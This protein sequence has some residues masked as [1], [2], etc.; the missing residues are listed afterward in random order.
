MYKKLFG[1]LRQLLFPP[2]CRCCGRKLLE[3]ESFL[4]GDCMVELPLT[5]QCDHPYNNFVTKKFEDL[6]IDK[7]CCMFVYDKE[8]GYSNIVKDVKF[9]REFRLGSYFGKTFGDMIDSSSEFEDIDF[10]LPVPLHWRRHYLRGYNQSEI[11]AKEIA[12]SLDKELITKG[13]T[14]IKSTHPQSRLKNPIE[15]AENMKNAFKVKNPELFH[16]KHILIV[17]DVTTTG[18]TI[19]SMV[20]ALNSITP[21]PTISIATLASTH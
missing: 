18:E 2:T 1:S 7:A 19:K 6:N 5:M 21:A 8:H 11:I 3:T 20:E 15:R 13:I 9:G 10:V 4:C 17:D 12:L 14:R 16:A